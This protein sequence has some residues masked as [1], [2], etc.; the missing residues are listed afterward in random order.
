[1]I[2]RAARSLV[3][4]GES[5]GRTVCAARIS[6]RARDTLDQGCFARTQFSHQS[7]HIPRMKCLGKTLSPGLHFCRAIKRESGKTHILLRDACLAG[8]RPSIRGRAAISDQCTWC[9]GSGAELEPTTSAA[10]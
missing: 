7:N 3:F 8:T 9:Q 5:K 4:V 2:Y 6:P 1:M 10:R